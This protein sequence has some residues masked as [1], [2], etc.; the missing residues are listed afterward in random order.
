MKYGGGNEHVFLNNREGERTRNF[1]PLP[2]IPFLPKIFEL[3][4]KQI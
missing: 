2:F 4:D 3:A 1:I